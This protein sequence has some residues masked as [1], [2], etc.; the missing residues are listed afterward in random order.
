MSCF[1]VCLSGP[2]W[3]LSGGHFGAILEA[4][5]PIWCILGLQCGVPVE[6]Q[7][8]DTTGT[9]LWDS[10]LP[11]WAFPGGHRGAF[12]EAIAVLGSFWVPKC[13]A[14]PARVP[15]RSHFVFFTSGQFLTL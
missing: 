11:L 8:S 2:I 14:G 6:G 5:R 3:R 7:I 10:F 1:R 12:L 9:S 15:F 4:Q 13:F